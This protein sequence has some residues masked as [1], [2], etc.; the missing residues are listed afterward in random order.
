METVIGTD[1]NNTDSDF[2]LLNDFEEVQLDSDPLD[3]D[4]NSDGLS[5][6]VEVNNGISMDLT[7]ITSLT[8]GIMI[9]TATE[10]T[11]EPTCPRL[12]NRPLTNIPF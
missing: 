4:T 10:L 2:D 9:M 6:Y 11:M 1:F 5:D 12:L 3:P 7:M 8:C